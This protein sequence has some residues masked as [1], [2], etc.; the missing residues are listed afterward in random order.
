MSAWNRWAA[1]PFCIAQAAGLAACASM[2][3]PVVLTL[4][5]AASGSASSAT[6]PANATRVLSL[7]RPEI[8]EYLA[9]RRVRYRVDTSTLAEWPNTYWAERLEIGVLRE[10]SSALR[11][12]LP[13][14][15]L[16]EVRCG[17]QSPAASLQVRLN[18]MD[19]LRN[20]RRLQASVHFTLWSV[21]RSPRLLHSEAHSYDISGD[22]DTAQSQARAISELL[23]R[24]A[25]DVSLSLA[26]VH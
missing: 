13:G 23:R 17:E 2:P 12:R 9:T 20:Q 18:R 4:P 24:V 10:F 7:S 11:E 15:R 3:A 19:Y 25:E 6:A 22:G 16:C 8:P 26:A 1:L 5:P 21:E 14:W